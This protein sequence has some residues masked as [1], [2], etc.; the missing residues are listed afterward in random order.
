M[1][2][3]CD[4]C[5]CVCADPVTLF[6]HPD[7]SRAP[8]ASIAWRASFALRLYRVRNHPLFHSTVG[9]ARQRASCTVDLLSVALVLTPTFCAL[10]LFCG[11]LA[12]CN[13]PCCV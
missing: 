10:V 1:L 8:P 11:A 2:C 7:P 4:V 12:S 9:P 5:V 13:R 6:Y 3:V